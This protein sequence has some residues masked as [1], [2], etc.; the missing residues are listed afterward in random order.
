MTTVAIIP[1]RKGSK[2]IPGKNLRPLL[3]KPLVQWTIEQALAA[4]GIDEVWVSSDWAE[5]RELADRLG[6]QSFL[7]SK[8]TASDE[9]STESVIDELLYGGDPE[10]VRIVLLQPTS[11]NRRVED[12]E[13]ALRIYQDG[14]HDSLFSGVSFNRFLWWQRG[15]G[16]DYH[17]GPLNYTLRQKRPRRQDIQYPQWLENGSI[18]IFDAE[19]YLD[20]R[21]RNRLFGNIG[22]YEMEAWT[23][24]ELD[25]EEDWGIME[26]VMGRQIRQEVVPFREVVI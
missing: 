24:F 2:G 15:K 23:Q 17:I 3:G 10:E 26:M 11:P 8:K 16:E 18:Y 25:T 9:A 4:T 1:A 7:R 13:N 21:P 6:A 20:N 19:K 5:L 14:K 12:I 22:V